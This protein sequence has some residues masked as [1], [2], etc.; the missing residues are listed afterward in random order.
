MV[1]SGQ[2]LPN[3]REALKTDINPVAVHE[4]SYDYQDSIQ[5]AFISSNSHD[6]YT[7]GAASGLSGCCAGGDSDPS[8]QY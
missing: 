5:D 6:C 1:V 2:S 7:G 8:N 3:D 4:L